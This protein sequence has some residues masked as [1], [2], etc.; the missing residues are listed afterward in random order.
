MILI[1]FR[2]AESVEQPGQPGRII[3]VEPDREVWSPERRQQQVS[4]APQLVR[5]RQVDGPI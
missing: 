2:G 5:S 3:A 1:G 4:G